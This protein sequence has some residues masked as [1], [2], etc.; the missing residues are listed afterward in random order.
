M[1]WN[2][3]GFSWEQTQSKTISSIP[4]N[5]ESGTCEEW[6]LVVDVPEAIAPRDPISLKSARRPSAPK[7]LSITIFLFK[8]V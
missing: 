4:E 2:Y 8:A 5:A 6:E 1:K 7:D 3:L